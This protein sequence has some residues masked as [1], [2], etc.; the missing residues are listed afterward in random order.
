MLDQHHRTAVKH[1]S[2]AIKSIGQWLVDLVTARESPLPLLHACMY[3]Q[4]DLDP[5]VQRRLRK[6]I[7]SAILSTDM[8]N[9][10][11]LTQDFKKHG[12]TVGACLRH[13]LMPATQLCKLWEEW[14]T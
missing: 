8:T 11:G 6:L 4:A 12:L 10:F 14:H 5:E 7:V 13:V 9:H 1:K 2:G 3:A